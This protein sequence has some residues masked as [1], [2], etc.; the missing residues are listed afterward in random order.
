MNT[1]EHIEAGHY[2]KDEKGRAL[3][4]HKEGGV[5]T[6]F[7]TSGSDDFPIIG[8]RFGQQPGPDAWSADSSV[9]LPPSPRKVVRWAA[10]SHEQL[11]ALGMYESDGPARREV[12][13]GKMLVQVEYEEPWA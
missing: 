9:L 5:V 10:L 11:D 12:C 4:P 6:V 1:K 8:W 2:P 3:V 13:G 7:A